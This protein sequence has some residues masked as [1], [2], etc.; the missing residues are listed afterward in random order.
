MTE[1]DD[2]GLRLPIH[3]VQLIEAS[4]GTGKTFTLA[5][6]YARLVIETGLP[7]SA[8]LAV[9][10]T[11]AATKELRGRLRARLVLAQRLLKTALAAAP[12]DLGADDLLDSEETRLTR[13][14]LRAAVEREGAAALYRRLG[15]ACQQMDLAPVHTI[16][17]FCR[18]AL[19]DHALEAGQSLLER[20]LLA[21]EAALRREV[22]LEFWR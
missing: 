6:L 17:G 7:V 8:I 16:H 12:F 3:G 5:T 14:L 10:F 4:A 15:Q 2:L 18:R 1:S 13:Q 9:T 22:A 21:N 11:E 20:E 19:A